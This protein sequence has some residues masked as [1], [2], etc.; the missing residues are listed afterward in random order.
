MDQFSLA[1]AMEYVILNRTTCDSIAKEGTRTIKKY[2]KD[3]NN[4]GSYY[5]KVFNEII[6]SK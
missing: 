3:V 4:A 5:L 6:N 1:K 2:V